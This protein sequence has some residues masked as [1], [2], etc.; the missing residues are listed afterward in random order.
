MANNRSPKNATTKKT[1]SKRPAG[2]RPV[3]IKVL[4]KMVFPF[5]YKCASCEE[6]EKLQRF[7]VTLTIEK[8]PNI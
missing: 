8:V 6:E 7:Q 3:H 4:K 1:A 5:I 2:I